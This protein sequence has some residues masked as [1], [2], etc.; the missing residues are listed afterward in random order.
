M[1]HIKHNGLKLKTR[2]VEESNKFLKPKVEDKLKK[3]KVED[4]LKKPKVIGQATTASKKAH[5]IG[6]LMAMI[7]KKTI[8]PK[9]SASKYAT[10]T[11]EELENRVA[12]I[13]EMISF[14]CKCMAFD[15]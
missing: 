6:Q 9:A 5:I 3:P 15:G 14:V 12:E 1:I 4:T 2:K 7:S 10:W 13:D 11:R 8:E